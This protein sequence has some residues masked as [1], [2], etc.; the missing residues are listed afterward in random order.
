MTPVN[1][2]FTS[3]HV[4]V[5]Q[6]LAKQNAALEKQV[7]T[8]RKMD[9]TGKRATKTFGGLSG[10]VAGVAGGFISLAAAIGLVNS[11]LK[12]IERRQTEAARVQVTIGQARKDVIRN[13]VGRS[14]AEI[15]D[16]LDEV[17]RVARK[18]RVAERFIAAGFATALS[19]SGG[20]IP[21]SKAAVGVATQFLADRPSGIGAFAGSLLDVAKITKT[22]DA[23]INLGFLAKVGSLSRVTDPQQQ[24]RSIPRAII[25]AG[26]FGTQ[27]TPGAALFA[28][29]TTGAA[30]IEGRISGTAMIGLAQQLE[31]FLPKLQTTTERITALQEAPLKAEQFLA[32]ATFEKVLLGPIRQLLTDVNSVT[33]REF[34]K[35]LTAIPGLSEL[36][37][38]GRKTIAQRALDP[39]ERTAQIKRLFAGAAEEFGVADPEGITGAIRKGLKDALAASG[40]GALALRAQLAK[41]RVLTE[42]GADPFA[43]ATDILN[44]RAERIGLVR[45]ADDPRLQVLRNVT[46]E[47]ERLRSQQGRAGRQGLLPPGPAREEIEADAERHRRRMQEEVEVEDFTDRRRRKD[48]ESTERINRE[49]RERKER[50][51]GL[52]EFED[53]H[54][55]R[56]RGIREDVHRDAELERAR[57][58]VD[59]LESL[60][61]NF[62]RQRKGTNR[63]IELARREEGGVTQEDLPGFQENRR[64]LRDAT[65]ELKESLGEAVK[66]L[67][68]LS[69]AAGGAASAVASEPMG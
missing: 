18:E 63:L 52:F 10:K 37:E 17:A 62:E 11:E 58:E 21:A 43:T 55:K 12:E 64:G 25:G 24:A 19:A 15:Q 46:R 34:R 16:V 31:E 14:D 3:D 40:L 13:L 57:R 22:A 5:M 28:A 48:E 9:R 67:K 29:L 61:E 38:V 54:Q 69:E 42:F 65:E 51:L 8:L 60:L 20:D 49:F 30:D 35:N 53:S 26:A 50:G 7:G 33:A 56:L 47:L 27:A 68:E 36:A 23:L 59:R 1:I 4:K 66:M 2:V 6:G 45:G 44:L 41:F 39:L 32:K